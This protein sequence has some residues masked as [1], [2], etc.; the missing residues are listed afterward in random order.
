M[1][2]AQE[3]NASFASNGLST[4]GSP[5]EPHTT[6]SS[7]TSQYS[8]DEGAD[9]EQG[10]AGLGLDDGIANNQNQNH[11]ETDHQFHLAY[12]GTPT[13]Y[14]PNFIE[15]GD[16]LLSEKRLT[17]FRHLFRNDRKT[18]SLGGGDN[19]DWQNEGHLLEPP[20]YRGGVRSANL[21]SAE[22]M[23]G[24]YDI[25]N[26]ELPPG[27][28][29]FIDNEPQL[30]RPRQ[31]N[32][33]G[34]F[35]QGPQGVQT[36]SPRSSGTPDKPGRKETQPSPIGQLW[37]LDDVND[38]IFER[39]GFAGPSRRL[40]E[41]NMDFLESQSK[42]AEPREI[43]SFNPFSLPNPWL[44]TS[45]PARCKR[46]NPMGSTGSNI[47]PSNVGHSSLG[48][49]NFRHHQLQGILF[50]QGPFLRPAFGEPDLPA[51]A[52]ASFSHSSL[53]TTPESRMP[54]IVFDRPRKSAQCQLPVD[55]NDPEKGSEDDTSCAAEASCG[56]SQL[57]RE[58]THSDGEQ[59]SR[60]S[61]DLPLRMADIGE[62]GVDQPAV[63]SSF[64]TNK[65]RRGKRAPLPI[66]LEKQLSFTHERTHNETEHER[67][68]DG[69]DQTGGF[70]KVMQQGFSVNSIRRRLQQGEI[71]NGKLE[72]KSITLFKSLNPESYTL[73]FGSTV[74]LMKASSPANLH[75]SMV[76]SLWTT[77]KRGNERLN[78]SY[79]TEKGPIIFL[80]S[81]AS[82]GKINGMAQMTGPWL[83]DRPANFWVPDPARN[84]GS[85]EVQWAY[86]KDVPMSTFTP[87][88]SKS[89]KP[90]D[91]KALQDAHPFVNI[92]P[93]VPAVVLTS[94]TGFRKT[95]DVK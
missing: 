80:F 32:D 28:L 43:T 41:G 61:S 58:D 4:L 14:V 91:V 25:P 93:N 85:F 54:A 72:L 35:R 53:H 42:S 47:W 71:A 82:S 50:G 46:E 39:D 78:A 17:T 63:G 74:F 27:K 30:L 55:S 86:C 2:S 23:P 21:L 49:S 18:A 64:S 12:P 16:P 73:P 31:L 65:K 75:G 83:R 87:M 44:Q 66:A 70:S 11:V 68:D 77:T 52:I 10:I 1:K 36:P 40:F 8:G 81:L 51:E 38:Q 15:A 90:Y 3:S 6:A 62:I 69:V 57:G 26:T 56:L 94:F 67:R 60:T 88:T 84:E 24:W 20:V 76:N 45:A 89:G 48:R 7:Q 9:V 22:V 37:S 19:V 33:D 92:F 95:L 29:S 13:F 5:F 79:A 59:P 34:S